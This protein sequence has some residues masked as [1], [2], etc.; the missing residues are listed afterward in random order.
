M[1]ARAVSSTAQQEGGG[2]AALRWGCALSLKALFRLRARPDAYCRCIVGGAL[3]GAISGG[4]A[5]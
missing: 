3:T 1:V 5:N 2:K 4:G